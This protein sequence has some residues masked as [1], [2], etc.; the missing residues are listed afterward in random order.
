MDK[1]K[2]LC[3][4]CISWKK[5]L[6]LP[7]ICKKCYVEAMNSGSV[8]Y[9]C[10]KCGEVEGVRNKDAEDLFDYNDSYAENF[11]LSDRIKYIEECVSC[12]KLEK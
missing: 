8:L 11:D 2:K 9:V 6:Y 4:T 3:R 7:G 10:K 1:E 12:K 5:E